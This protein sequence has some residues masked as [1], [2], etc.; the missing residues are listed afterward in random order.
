MLRPAALQPASTQ[1]TW[2]DGPPYRL[3]VTT[4]KGGGSF[5]P[6]AD[7]I[8]GGPGDL[9][10]AAPGRRPPPQPAAGGGGGGGGGGRVPPR[11]GHQV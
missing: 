6:R 3:Y 10:A 1:G 8:A 11:T 4:R 9:K 2:P 5:R 7:G